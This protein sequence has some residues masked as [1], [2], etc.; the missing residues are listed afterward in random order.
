M[1]CADLLDALVGAVATRPSRSPVKPV[2][3]VA[4]RRAEATD[5]P[6]V[7]PL[8][9]ALEHPAPRPRRTPHSSERLRELAR[10][11]ARRWQVTLQQ[12]GE[13]LLVA[14]STTASVSAGFVTVGA[15]GATRAHR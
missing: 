7:D 2:A 9:R 12:P 8:A 1:I 4:D 3:V 10:T 6:R 14:V 13:R 11:A 15:S 5:D